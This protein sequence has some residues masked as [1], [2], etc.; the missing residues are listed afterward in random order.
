MKGSLATFVTE[1]RKSSLALE[2]VFP[3]SQSSS[4]S[5]ALSG[6]KLRKKGSVVLS[7]TRK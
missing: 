5:A 4:S 2:L 6:I 3:R 7:L 1:P